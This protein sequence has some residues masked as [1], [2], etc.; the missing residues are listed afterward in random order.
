VV[1]G[2]TTW[3][4][5]GDVGAGRRSDLRESDKKSQIPTSLGWTPPAPRTPGI[6]P[7]GRKQI[8]P[9]HTGHSPMDWIKYGLRDR[10]PPGP[11]AAS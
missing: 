8:T 1:W 10:T 11:R 9:R 2:T 3:T 7:G 4:D 6:S 5:I